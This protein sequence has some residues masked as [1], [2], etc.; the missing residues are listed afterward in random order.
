M[1]NAGAKRRRTSARETGKGGPALTA[2]SGK[3]QA[4]SQP[5]GRTIARHRAHVLVAA[6]GVDRAVAGVLP[7]PVEGV[8]GVA[9]EREDVALLE[10]RRV[11]PS[12]R[13]S[14]RAAVT[15]AAE[16]SYPTTS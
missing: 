16:K 5:P 2:R 6:G 11:T 10:G 9:A 12:R 14:A 8:V 15:A 1:R 3:K 7:H 4:S 13:A